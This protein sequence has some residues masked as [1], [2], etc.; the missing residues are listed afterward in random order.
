[1]QI[2]S[3][4]EIESWMC[5]RALPG[6]PYQNGG[7]R[8]AFY[9]Q[10]YPPKNLRGVESFTHGLIHH[11]ARDD[12]VLMT[13]TDTEN[14]ERYELRLFDRLRKDFASGREILDAPGHLFAA[15]G[16]DDVI[17]MFALTVAFQWEAYLHFPAT[18]SI[19]LNWEGD[20]IDFWT[21]DRNAFDAV[22]TM[23]DAFKL[24]EVKA[25]QPGATENPGDA[26]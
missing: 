13:I 15:A 23:I 7:D 17:P 9:L 6:D 26:Q 16:Y 2:L 11:L 22:S 25:A 14:P 10:F 1:M 21:D 8:L 18:R 19:I 5:R 20:I 12:E 24:K 3:K 4:T